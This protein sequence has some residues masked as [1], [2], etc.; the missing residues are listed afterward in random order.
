MPSAGVGL[1]LTVLRPMG[2][3][4]ISSK[5]TL[6]NCL[7]S[8]MESREG[9]TG[10]GEEGDMLVIGVGHG[11]TGTLSM[12]EAMEILGLGPCYHMKENFIRNHSDL[13]YKLGT[14]PRGDPATPLVLCLPR[15]SIYDGLSCVCVLE[16]AD[17]GVPERQT[18]AYGSRSGE[19]V[20]QCKGD[21]KGIHA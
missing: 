7:F 4:N 14:M 21:D 2:I 10:K 13:W 15:V 5:L 1:S 3:H 12:K 18:G 17:G 20:H 16:G 6:T 9:A 11:R 19:V 8:Q